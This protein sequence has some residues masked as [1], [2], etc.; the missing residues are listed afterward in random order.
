MIFVI[1]TRKTHSKRKT[2]SLTHNITKYWQLMCC[3]KVVVG[4]PLF[5]LKR[6]SI[7]VR[8]LEFR[9]DINRRC[10]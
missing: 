9:T 1:K 6:T 2:H 4:N 10:D 8:K 3:M 7:H 5:F